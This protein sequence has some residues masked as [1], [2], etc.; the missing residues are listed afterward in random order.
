M[1]NRYIKLSF[2]NA[3]LFPK[4]VKTKDFVAR[5]D[6]N[7]KDKLYFKRC[8]RALIEKGSFKEPITVHQISNVLHAFVG[9]RPVPSFRKTFYKPDEFLFN[10]ANKSFLKIDSPKITKI[11]KGDVFESYIPEFTKVNKSASDSWTK[12]PTIQWFKVKKFMGEYYDEFIILINTSL[13]YD[14]TKEPFET[15]K[16]LYIKEGVKL[17]EVIKFLLEKQKTPIVNFLQKES[18]DRSEITKNKLLGETITSGIDTC[19]FLNGEILVPYEQSF[20]DKLTKNSTN[21]LDGGMVK[22]VGI[23]YEDEITDTENFTLVSE[24]SDEKY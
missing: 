22:I 7:A 11:I 9:E 5:I 20:V 15:L 17:D 8:S 1:S 13:G 19:F 16:N 12:A 6:V 4:N 24:I 14:V 10:L 2:E 3:K 23:F 18:P 21:I